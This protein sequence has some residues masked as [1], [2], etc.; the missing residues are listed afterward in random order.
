[1]STDPRSPRVHLSDEGQVSFVHRRWTASSQVNGHMGCL[2]PDNPQAV[3]RPVHR[4]HVVTHTV[5]PTLCTGVRG[6]SPGCLASATEPPI[7]CSVD[8]TSLRFADVG[9]G[10]LSVVTR[11]PVRH[12]PCPLSRALRAARR[13]E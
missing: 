1:M 8:W 12:E 2:S 4:I 13:A 11:T 9:P 6:Q 10:R 5:F 7:A 3:H